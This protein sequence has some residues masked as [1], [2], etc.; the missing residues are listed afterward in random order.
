MRHLHLLMLLLSGVQTVVACSTTSFNSTYDAYPDCA[1]TC[2][3]C[4][5]ASYSRNFANNCDYEAGECCTS[6]Y[7]NVIAE[8]WSCVRTT[9]GEQ[10]SND[11]FG[12]FVDFCKEK[13]HALEEKNVPE[14]YKLPEAEDEGKKFSLSIGAIIGIAI[15]GVSCIATII[16]V[17]IKYRHYRRKK[18][19]P[20]IA[21]S[22]ESGNSTQLIHQPQPMTLGFVANAFGRDGGDVNMTYTRNTSTT[23][24]THGRVVTRE[25]IDVRR[26]RGEMSAR[27]IVEEI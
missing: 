22:V 3:A 21:A 1:A 6:A 26:I 19:N 25:V 11:A 7:H 10:V 12:T 4:E 16:G 9:C 27:R 8:T 24:L 18:N 14:G 13:D 23:S 2:L 5:D 15:G 20:S 17:I